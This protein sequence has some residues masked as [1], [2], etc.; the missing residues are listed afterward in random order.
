MKKVEQKRNFD[1]KEE[2]FAEDIYAGTV[3]LVKEIGINAS[4]Q[5]NQKVINK[6]ARSKIVG[7]EIRRIIFAKHGNEGID[8][9]NYNLSKKHRYTYKLIESNEKN[10]DSNDIFK[11]NTFVIRNTQNVGSLL[12]FIG[13]SNRIKKS[14][15]RKIK[16]VLCTKDTKINI[17]KHRLPVTQHGIISLKN[18]QKANE[19][20]IALAEFKKSELPIKLQKQ[21][22]VYAKYFE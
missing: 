9:F 2:L 22:K 1:I 11:N 20:A 5:E 4:P 15:L 21:E 18:A 16:R 12:S 8:L 7:L 17:Y 3:V 19:E 14:D 13:F 10:T 6:T